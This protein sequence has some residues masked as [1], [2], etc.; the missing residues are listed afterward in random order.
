LLSGASLPCESCSG[1]VNVISDFRALVPLSDSPEIVAVS[2]LAFARC[3][4]DDIHFR[5]S[6]SE[7]EMC[8]SH[9]TQSFLRLPTERFAVRYLGALDSPRRILPSVAAVPIQARSQTGCPGWR[10]GWRGDWRAIANRRS[11]RKRFPRPDAIMHS[12]SLFKE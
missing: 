2:R 4:T 10:K 7:A 6:E 8:A 12:A 1:I 5:F 3:V 11:G 9:D